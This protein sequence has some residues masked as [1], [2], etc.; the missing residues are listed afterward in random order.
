[1]A[2]YFP[3]VGFH[4]KV[5]V[6]GISPNDN[7]VR[8]TEVGGLNAELSTEEIAEG[9]QNRFL[10]KYPVRTKHTDLVLKRGMLTNSEIIKWLRECIEDFIITPKNIDIKL[11]NEEHQ[12]LLTWHVVNAY[13]TKWT[14]SDLSASNNSVVVETLQFFY[15]YFSVDKG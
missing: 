5:E 7:D 2:N 13:P 11:L 15:Q 3:P 4:F 6:L 8:F 1:M 9:G 10:Q 12:P 14:V